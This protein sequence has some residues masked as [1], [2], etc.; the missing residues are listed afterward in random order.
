MLDLIVNGEQ[1]DLMTSS[2]GQQSPAPTTSLT[3]PP[4]AELIR[5]NLIHELLWLFQSEQFHHH[6][7]NTLTFRSRKIGSALRFHFFNLSRDK[8]SQGHEHSNM[9]EIIFTCGLWNPE[10][11]VVCCTASVHETVSIRSKVVTSSG[12]SGT[13][14]DKSCS[15]NEPQPEFDSSNELLH[16]CSME[17]VI[18]RWY[19]SIRDIRLGPWTS[20]SNHIMIFDLIPE[21]PTSLCWHQIPV[22][23]DLNKV[24]GRCILEAHLHSGVVLV[25]QTSLWRKSL[26]FFLWRPSRL[27]LKS[28]S[29]HLLH[30]FPLHSCISPSNQPFSFKHHRVWVQSDML[31]AWLL[32]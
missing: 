5:K 9:R 25:T 22:L 4:T 3:S 16:G 21:W 7:C 2:Q 23:L 8:G 24:F 20:F 19:V 31:L 11:H 12:Y 28:H 1:K 15:C 14:D 17:F 27:H 13:S 30:L 18:S 26:L 10:V 32:A 29:L 6:L